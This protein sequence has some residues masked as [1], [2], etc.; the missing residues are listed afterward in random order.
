MPIRG[1]TIYGANVMLTSDDEP[2]VS[3]EPVFLPASM[4]DAAIT[5]GSLEPGAFNNVT[6]HPPV[7]EWPEHWR[8]L[9]E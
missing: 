6:V 3:R 7:S 2:S 1:I 9:K 4:I 8:H 5:D